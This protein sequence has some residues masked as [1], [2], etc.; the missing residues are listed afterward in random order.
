MTDA[1]ASGLPLARLIN[2]AGNVVSAS[3]SSVTYAVMELGGNLNSRLNALLVDGASDNVWPLTGYS[4]FLIRTNTH[5]GSC[6]ER[7]AAMKFLY[8]FYYSYAVT[9]IALTLDY[10]TLPGFIRNIVVS[11]LVN[12]AKCSTGEYALAQYMHCLL[13]T[14]DA[15][16]E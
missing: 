11:K 9:E 2:R 10:A 13:Y 7:K 3:G 12:S 8:N 15:A 1:K 14:S 6:D 16:D 5:L 4:Y